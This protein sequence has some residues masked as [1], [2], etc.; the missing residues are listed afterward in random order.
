MNV[1]F[2]VFL[3]VISRLEERSYTPSQEC[4]GHRNPKN[5]DHNI[6]SCLFNSTIASA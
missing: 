5:S 2:V 1:L 3:W 4:K 6:E